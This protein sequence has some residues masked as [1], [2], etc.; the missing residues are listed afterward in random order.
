MR[1]SELAGLILAAALALPVAGQQAG[2][3]TG[4]VVDK[5]GRQPLNGVQVSV[6]GTTRGGLT[7]ARGRYTIAGVA[8]GQHTVRATYIG[9]RTETQQV[10]VAG[11][12]AATLDFEMGVSAVSLDE[13]VVTGT[14]GAVEKKQLGATVSTVSVANVQERMPVMDVGTVLQSR[15]PGVRSVGTVGGVG[16]SRDLRIRGTSSMQLGQRP[17]VYVDGVKVD[18]RGQEWGSGMGTSCCSFSG[19]AGVDR[20]S[21]LNPNDI[22]RIEVIK[23]A[24]AGT[25]YGS[26]ATNGVIQIFTKRGRSDS[27]PRWTAQATTGFQRYRQN[28]PTKLYPTFTGQDGTRALD[29][30]ETLVDNGPYTG[31]DMTVQGGSSTA[32]YFVSGG[33]VSEQGSIQ[34]NWMKR[35]NLRLNLHWLKGDKLSFDVTSAYTRNRIFE[36]QSG[37]NWTALL[38]NALY[39]TPYNA[40]AARP[41]GEPWVPISSIEKMETT[42]DVNR[43]TGG[44]TLNYNPVAR[45]TNKFQLGLDALNEERSRLQPFGHPY[46]FVPEGEKGIGYRNFRSVTAEYL[47]TLAFDQILPNLSSRISFGAQGFQTMIRHSFAVG[48]GY[49]APGVTTVRGG[50][51]RT[52]DELFEEIVQV[53]FFGQNRFSFYDRLYLTTGVRVDGNSAFGDNYGFQVYPNVQ[54]SYDASND[55]WKPSLISNL[56]FRGAVG[57]AGLAP[58]AFDKFLTFTPFTTGENE[59]GVRPNDPGNPDLGPERTTEIEAGFEAGFLNERVGLDLTVYRRV[60]KDA[61]LDV[62]LPPSLR[63]GGEPRRNVGEILDQGY[64]VA[65]RV[66]PIESSRLRWSA[67]VR[68]DGNHN[69]ITDLGT[70]ADTAIKRLGNYR[71]GLPVRHSFSRKTTGWNPTTRAFTLTDT[72][73]LIGRNLPGFNASLGNEITFGAFRFYALFSLEQGAWFNNGTRDQSITFRTNDEYLSLL[74]DATGPNCLAP[75]RYVD[76]ARRLCETA[77]SDSTF[78]WASAIAVQDK[79][80]NVRLRELSL[81]YVVPEAL[82]A[83]LGLSRTMITLAGQNLHWWDGCH[84]LDPNVNYQGGDDDGVASGYLGTPQPRQFKLSIRTSF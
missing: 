35:G 7:D 42:D 37:N 12:Q 72:T 61:I 79:R 56:R 24:A 45:F 27:A 28:F 40:S 69:E 70:R 8:L 6:D 30:N 26:E 9:Y 38:G 54:M 19:G 31:V 81:S 39:G 22:D 20:L 64:E 80:D 44:V 65:L 62:A 1:C 3:I 78:K 58:G 59:S 43:W 84:C 77:A 50:R 21:D 76:A 15:L 71:V 83:K 52:G 68:V 33:Y 57:T 53:G 32:T 23:G 11:P 51:T 82:S 36:L 18:N 10:A 47:A 17:V 48:N 5:A 4:T 46:T 16:A 66:T 29:P 67:D 73:V 74:G 55:S 13:V 34:P 2:S 41:Y 60:T 14:A 49:A 25:L 75:I 63:F